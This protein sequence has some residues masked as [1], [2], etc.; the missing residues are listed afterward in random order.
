V[1]FCR[2]LSIK[3]QVT[4]WAVAA[5]S[6]C[7]PI[8]AGKV[9]LQ[10]GKSAD[11]NVTGYRVRIV[12]ATAGS[13]TF[14]DVGNT[15]VTVVDGLFEGLTYKLA[16]MAYTRNGIESDPSA[17]VN[18]TVPALSGPNYALQ[19]GKF[20]HGTAQYSPH[21]TMGAKGEMFPAGT[22]VTLTAMPATGYVCSGWTIN[23][24][25]V[26]NNPAF[27]S[28]T[29][30]AVVT[31]VIKKRG[32]GNPTPADPTQMPIQWVSSGGNLFLSVGGE[33]GAWIL[34]G[35]MDFKEWSQV[36][37]GLTSQQVPAPLTHAYSYYRVRQAQLAAF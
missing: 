33:M 26:P 30:N 29:Q 21:G 2:T 27:V 17:V 6:L 4:V 5:I 18:Y 14:V 24:T 37:T 8:E 34:E 28:M 16:V 3:Q 32:Q 15:N 9:S 13:S 10:W 25:V 11:P 36:A 19:F 23:S 1:N 20:T 22:V 35:T 31:P 12:E 7:A